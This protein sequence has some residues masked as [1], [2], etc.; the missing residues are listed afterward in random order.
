MPQQ[1]HKGAS[2]ML[3]SM[4]QGGCITVFCV[5][6]AC[7]IALGGRNRGAWFQQLAKKT[8][9]MVIKAASA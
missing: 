9:G 1:D 4:R 6:C 8:R 2:L 5:L 7:G 3:L